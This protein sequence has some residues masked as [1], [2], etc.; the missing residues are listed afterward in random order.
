MGSVSIIIPALNEE[1]SLG[2]TL[3]CLSIL[4]PAARE[5][6]VV[7][8]GSTDQTLAV[9]EQFDVRLI[10][11]DQPGR[12]RQMNTGAKVATGDYLCFLHADTLVPDDLV[13][14]IETTLA[15]PAIACGGF[16]SLMTG[17]Q[18]TR[19]LTSLH[20]CAKTYYAPLIP[21]SR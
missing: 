12:S 8:G 18:Q 2:R 13:S 10:E 15:D 7:D 16:I 5:V 21:N 11:A 3:R 9:A 17:P 19:W 4:S 20:N 6:I 14:L 1:R